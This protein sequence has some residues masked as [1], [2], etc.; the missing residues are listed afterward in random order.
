VS[1][2]ARAD[3]SE[4]N[5]KS[6]SCVANKSVEC[7]YSEDEDSY[8]TAAVLNVVLRT[9]LLSKS[10]KN[11]LSEERAKLNGGKSVNKVTFCSPSSSYRAWLRDEHQAELQKPD[12]TYEPHGL[13]RRELSRASEL[14]DRQEVE[15]VDD[16]EKILNAGDNDDIILRPVPQGKPLVNNILMCH[17]TRTVTIIAEQQLRFALLQFVQTTFNSNSIMSLLYTSVYGRLL[18]K[19]PLALPRDLTKL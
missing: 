7:F 19:V 16:E 15:D 11:H 14:G 2:L 10:D 9:Q 4:K 3:L 1:F 13:N 12:A 8:D 6:L 17:I 5:G 18:R